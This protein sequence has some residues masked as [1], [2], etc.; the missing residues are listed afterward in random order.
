MFTI[1]QP[2]SSKTQHI[3]PQINSSKRTENRATPPVNSTEDL[4]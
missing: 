3:H 4:T 1:G 2:S